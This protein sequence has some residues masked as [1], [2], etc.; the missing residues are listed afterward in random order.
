M[1]SR[2]AAGRLLACAAI[3]AAST[4]WAP[5]PAPPAADGRSPYEAG[6]EARRAGDSK[7]AAELLAAAVAAEPDN[8]DA[9]LQLGL[10]L[11][12][13][14]R[15]DE[16]EAAFRRTLDLA[17][18]YEDARLGLARVAIRRGDPKAARAALEGVSAANPEA[19]PLRARL[20]EEA[21]LTA[22]RGEIN[23]EGSY[24]ALDRG[25]SDWKEGAAELRYKTAGG[26]AIA[27]RV[28]R[29]RRFG[30]D[31]TYL[32]A[33]ADARLS[34]AASAYFSVGAT[35]N[36]D[37]RPR[38]QLSAGGS[39]RL[40]GGAGATV[41]TLDARQARYPARDIQTL[42]PGFEQYLAGGRV[43]LTGRMINIFDE[44]G[45][46]RAGWLARGDVQAS[47]KLRLFAG[48]ADAPDTSEGRVIATRSAFG[49]FA[50]D[51]GQRSVLRL[52]AAREHRSDGSNRVQLGLGVGFRF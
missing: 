11:L 19:A 3:M 41:A 7:R 22:Y 46:H 24:S 36:A 50:W 32:E 38:W 23:L 10:A 15:L 40:R 37:F 17:P 39:L 25:R 51:V 21:S 44:R 14:G 9:Q 8:S 42:T 45:R 52:S 2:P 33:R 13:E 5:P 18:G 28:E 29:S 34:P 6:V 30:L 48:Y 12:A 35:P 43:W 26:T 31:D 1:K 16:A 27:G 47:A 20:D 49:G 4:A